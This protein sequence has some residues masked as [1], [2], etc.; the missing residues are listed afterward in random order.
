[1]SSTT[2]NWENLENMVEIRR[3]CRLAAF[4]TLFT[5]FS[6]CLKI[7]PTVKA[8]VSLSSFN[9]EQSKV[10][11]INKNFNI[12]YLSETEK[13]LCITLCAEIYQI[14]KHALISREKDGGQKRKERKRE[15]DRQAERER[16]RL[17]HVG[18]FANNLVVTDYVQ[19]V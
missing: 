8:L 5:M 4:N 15:T 10:L 16:E 1:M 9:L 19:D 17:Y 13:L 14:N 12:T 3:K 6:I 2:L 7:N 11:S 18:H